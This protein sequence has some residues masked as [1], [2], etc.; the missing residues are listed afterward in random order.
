[1]CATLIGLLRAV[2]ALGVQ[3]DH[4]GRLC[5]ADSAISDRRLSGEK[6]TIAEVLGPGEQVW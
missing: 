4:G 2:T 5:R 6:A 3:F 1:M